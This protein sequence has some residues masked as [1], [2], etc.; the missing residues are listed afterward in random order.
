MEDS[1]LDE[2]A[3]LEAGAS[4][5]RPAHIES[6][7]IANGPFDW[8]LHAR[9]V[10][11]LAA[12]SAIILPATARAQGSISCAYW[13]RAARI[14]SRP[15]ELSGSNPRTISPICEAILRS[16]IANC[17]SARRA[18]MN[19]ALSGGTSR[20]LLFVAGINLEVQQSIGA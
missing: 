3:L 4:W 16:L 15:S 11:P 7:D 20:R 14:L 2:L 1:L 6:P 19:A 8:T 18:R 17:V 10:Y 12:I 5:R 9:S 13:L